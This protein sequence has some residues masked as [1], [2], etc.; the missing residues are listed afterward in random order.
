VKVEIS[1]ELAVRAGDLK[2]GDV[3]RR[4]LDTRLYLVLT[5][6]WGTQAS[7]VP[8]VDLT[9]FSPDSLDRA[10]TGRRVVNPVL[11]GAC[12]AP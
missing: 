2:P 6:H 1:L 3:F 10:N 12:P 7:G 4:D 9:D 8:V 5:R 11:T